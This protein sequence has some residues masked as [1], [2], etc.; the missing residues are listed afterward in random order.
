VRSASLL[1]P[2]ALALAAAISLAATALL[3]PSEPQVEQGFATNTLYVTVDYLPTTSDPA[4]S[5][6]KTEVEILGQVFEGLVRLNPGTLDPE[7]GAAASWSVSDDGLVY[8]FQLRPELRWSDGAPLVADHFVASVRRILD[9]KRSLLRTRPFI[10][11]R[12]GRDYKTGALPDFADVGVSVPEPG[13]IRFE[14][15]HPY[16][17]FLSDLAGPGGWPT[18]PGLESASLWPELPSLTVNGPFRV[19][20]QRDSRL[21]LRRNPHYWS[22]TL[23]K[24]E[25]AVLLLSSGQ[26][27]LEAMRYEAGAVHLSDGIAGSVAEHSPRR[28][29]LLVSPVWSTFYLRFDTG[30]APFDDARLRLAL[31]LAIDRPRLASLRRDPQ[32]FIAWSFVPPLLPDFP[33]T[34]ILEQRRAEARSL[35][36]AY[37]AARGDPLPPLTLHFGGPGDE[38]RQ[39]ALEIARSWR[40]TL[41]IAADVMP[42]PSKDSDDESRRPLQI[43]GVAG[44]RLDPANFLEGFG[45]G[46]DI[47]GTRW[48]NSAYSDLINAAR[49]TCTREDRIRSLAAA[50]ELLLTEAPVSP[51]FFGR[52]QQFVH[53]R[54]VGWRHNP[55]NVWSLREVAFR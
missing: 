25:R 22:P 34:R 10:H 35:L 43:V 21:V 16:P 54:V 36:D 40:E 1:V 48:V 46:K 18:P 39:A 7:P 15:A 37:L 12:G 13:L 19:E 32:D 20:S 31:S 11:L 38:L 4:R 9:P 44:S 42:A 30:T 33:R 29:E 6:A 50:E 3:G 55:L 27:T 8:T 45:G 2:G 14:L 41:G 26:S 5:A 49:T 17:H 23:P 52:V 51:V 28:G 47:A 53:P 24:L